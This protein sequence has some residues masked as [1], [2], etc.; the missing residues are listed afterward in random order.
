MKY[1]FDR[2][3]SIEKFLIYETVKD[4]E[5]RSR[6]NKGNHDEE[7]DIGNS[8][9][10]QGGGLVTDCTTSTWCKKKLKKAGVFFRGLQSLTNKI[11]SKSKTTFLVTCWYFW[12]NCS[13]TEQWNMF[14]SARSRSLLCS[15]LLVSLAAQCFSY[16]VH[17]C[18]SCIEQNFGAAQQ[19]YKST[20]ASHKCHFFCHLGLR[21]GW[22]D[23]RFVKKF[24]LMNLHP[25]SSSSIATMLYYIW[26]CTS[27]TTPLFFS[28]LA[29]PHW[30]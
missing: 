23:H 28:I 26:I 13:Q 9:P 11:F 10:S 20:S 6:R 25:S 24:Q 27:N 4:T 3:F 5:N 14:R 18:A 12:S 16:R 29:N 30:W 7:K 19:L 2:G 8:R 21:C 22:F 17:P 15:F 1:L